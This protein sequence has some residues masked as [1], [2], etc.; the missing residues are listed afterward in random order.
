MTNLQPS[1][2]VK[3]EE[4]VRS[5]DIAGLVVDILFTHYN[6][7]TC[8]D[9]DRTKSLREVYKQKTKELESL[10]PSPDISS[11]LAWGQR[12]NI[13][14]AYRVARYAR[15]KGLAKKLT[16]VIE[17]LPASDKTKIMSVICG[18]ELPLNKT[19]VPILLYNHSIENNKAVNMF[20]E[21]EFGGGYY[22]LIKKE[23]A[24]AGRARFCA[25][26]YSL[27]VDT[28]D[29]FVSLFKIGLIKDKLVEVS[30]ECDNRIESIRYVPEENKLVVNS[31]C[32]GMPNAGL[33]FEV[34]REAVVFLQN[35]HSS[36][37][38]IQLIQAMNN[39][40][41]KNGEVPMRA[42]IIDIARFAVAEIIAIALGTEPLDKMSERQS[43]SLMGKMVSY[44]CRRRGMSVDGATRLCLRVGMSWNSSEPVVNRFVCFFKDFLCCSYDGVVSGLFKVEACRFSDKLDK[45]TVLN[46]LFSAMANNVKDADPFSASLEDFREHLSK[47]LSKS[48]RFDLND[49]VASYG[50]YGKNETNPAKVL[51][52]MLMNLNSMCEGKLGDHTRW[53]EIMLFDGKRRRG[54]AKSLLG[55]NGASL[56]EI[57]DYIEAG[58]DGEY[59]ERRS[60]LNRFKKAMIGKGNIRSVASVAREMYSDEDRPAAKRWNGIIKKMDSKSRDSK[61]LP[62]LST[63]LDR[64]RFDSIAKNLVEDKAGYFLADVVGRYIVRASFVA[65]FDMLRNFK[66]EEIKN[67]IGASVLG[68]MYSVPAIIKKSPEAKLGLF[69]ELYFVAEEGIFAL[70]EKQKQPA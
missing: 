1:G 32:M 66:P 18:I 34:A 3:R 2:L 42:A 21:C 30:I 12:E 29:R 38:D 41:F 19:D 70:F 4:G 57:C 39:I 61:G 35:M 58:V 46:L 10:K 22:R 33:E 68:L 45:V 25:R 16:T 49:F 67:Y 62:Y 44:L 27:F 24:H 26:V 54:W 36:A 53:I 40:A 59:S 50:E 15:N 56:S 17:S 31:G 37:Q 69:A 48:V 47:D 52:Y 23:D 11:M 13:V 51:A 7:I 64:L 65:H 5:R 20:L 28:I 9:K 60:R 55:L 8:L 43:V 14:R 63:V 6:G